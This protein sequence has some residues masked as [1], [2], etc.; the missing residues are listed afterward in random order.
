[1]FKV[2]FPR[3][4]PRRAGAAPLCYRRPRRRKVSDC[5]VNEW[6]VELRARRQVPNGGDR[7]ISQT[8]VGVILITHNSMR[9]LESVLQGLRLQKHVDIYLII[10]DNGS[11]DSTVA[12]FAEACADIPGEIIPLESN[13]GYA[14]AV[15]IGIERAFRSSADYI[16]ILNHD[17]ELLPEALEEMISI[18]RSEGPFGPISPLHLSRDGSVVESGCSWFLRLG[19]GPP[20][21]V[22]IDRY[23]PRVILTPFVN[24]AVMLISRRVIERVGRF[25]DLFFFYCE[26]NDYCR[27]SVL[28]GFSP[29]VA[30][31]A[32]AYHWHASAREMNEFR[33][34]N[35]RRAN[36]LLILKKTTRPFVLNMG[37]SAIRCILDF[38]KYPCSF[39]EWKQIV[40]DYLSCLPK[41][42]LVWR[43]R[44]RDLACIARKCERTRNASDGSAI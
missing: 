44:R 3:I 16:L 43:S 25:D 28:C 18:D 31:Q 12:A 5:E 4:T 20:Q 41:I 7:S 6:L 17:V 26:D 40:T 36:Y 13:C 23:A 8:R 38:R 15:N 14:A 24:G 22:P 2:G 9:W 21:T 1:M 42:V 35:F 11:S 27:R 29:A 37:V 32:H 34:L 33:R 19:A 39:R 30:V 10:V